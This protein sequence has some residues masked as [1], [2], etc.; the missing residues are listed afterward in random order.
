MTEKSK[1]T[2]NYSMRH[3]DDWID[4]DDAPELTEADFNRVDLVWSVGDKQLNETEGK[5]AF[6]AA[7]KEQNEH[8]AIELD[9]DVIEWFKQ[10][11]DGKNY[12]T[13]INNYLKE[14]VQRDAYQ[15]AL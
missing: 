8:E 14:L 4:E 6:Q 9:A 2:V 1:N 12:K 11:A 5:V 3:E 7:L 10:K 13:Y 15:V